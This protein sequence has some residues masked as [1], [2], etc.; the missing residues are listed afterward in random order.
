MMGVGGDSYAR[1]GIAPGELRERLTRGRRR[2][3][4]PP[5]RISPV[6]VSIGVSLY[7]VHFCA[8]SRSNGHHLPFI[9]AEGQRRLR[10]C[11]APTGQRVRFTTSVRVGVQR[12]TDG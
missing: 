7:D 1:E 2:V 8:D 3:P 5:T 4:K 6:E 10:M 12:E 11:Q 9:V